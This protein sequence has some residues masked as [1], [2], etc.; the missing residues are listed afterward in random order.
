M[1]ETRQALIDAINGHKVSSV[2]YSGGYGQICIE[3]YHLD[4]HATTGRP[5]VSF[6]ATTPHGEYATPLPTLRDALDFLQVPYANHAL[7]PDWK[8]MKDVDGR[9]LQSPRHGDIKTT[10]RVRWDNG[11]A[12]DF[13]PGTFG[14]EETAELLGLTW[15]EQMVA[16]TPG[17]TDRDYTFDIIEVQSIEP[18]TTT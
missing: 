5:V 15:Q 2:V 8:S 14:D 4:N 11:H 1:D 13:L 10:Y 12:T 17:A 9:P 3:V 16:A 7:P 18:P 6:R